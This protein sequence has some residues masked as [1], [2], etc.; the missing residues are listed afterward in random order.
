MP[1]ES[2]LSVQ[3]LH[4]RLGPPSRVVDP[5]TSAPARH[6]NNQIHVYDIH[7]IYFIEHHYT[8][9][10]CD[11]TIVFWPEEHGFRFTPLR[12]FSGELRIAGYEMPPEPNLDSL[13]KVSPIGLK[14]RIGGMFNSRRNGYAVNLMARGPM[15]PSGRR[16]KILRLASISLSWP[17]DPWARP[18]NYKAQ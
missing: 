14:H 15:L 12:M 6:R 8:R 10:L 7:G 4:A 11:C 16:S 9:R 2:A 3:E 5:G 1:L 18:E 13:V 17:H